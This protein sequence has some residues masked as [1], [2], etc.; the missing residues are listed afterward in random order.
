MARWTLFSDD[1][2]HGPSR[3]VTPAQ[4]QQLMET[5]MDPTAPT[6]DD[7]INY[8]V[9]AGL[10]DDPDA[11]SVDGEWIDTDNFATNN[12]GGFWKSLLGG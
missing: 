5:I 12:T 10:I 9:R 7:A 8:A 6:R 4:A 3:E 11:I 1:G 2:R